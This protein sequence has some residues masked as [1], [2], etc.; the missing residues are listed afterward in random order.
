MADQPSVE[1][2]GSNSKPHIHSKDGFLSAMVKMVEE[3]N[4]TFKFDVTLLVQ[5]AIVSGLVVPQREYADAFA[6]SINEMLK[7]Q[8]YKIPDNLIKEIHANWVEIIAKS[9]PELDVALDF[10]HLRDVQHSA[11]GSIVSSQF[12]Y[13]RVDI[14]DV[15]GWTLGKMKMEEIR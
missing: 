7:I 9:T 4:S 14:H 6:F 8:E 12:P 3:P 10:I 11:I 1:N 2:N 15:S 5:G 13:W